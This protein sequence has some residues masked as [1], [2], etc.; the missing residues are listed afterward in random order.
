MILKKEEY[1]SKLKKWPQKPLTK[2][3]KIEILIIF[4]ERSL[5]TIATSKYLRNKKLSMS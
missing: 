5:L 3:D 1:L 4:A 2:N